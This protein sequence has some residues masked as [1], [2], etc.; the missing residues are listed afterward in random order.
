MFFVGI[1]SATDDIAESGSGSGS[2][3]VPYDTDTRHFKPGNA[4]SDKA[5]GLIITWRRSIHQIGMK[6]PT[7]LFAMFSDAGSKKLKHGSLARHNFHSLSSPIEHK[8]LVCVPDGLIDDDKVRYP[9]FLFE[10]L[11]P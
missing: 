11:F 5:A 2:G 9:R 7:V 6:K 10:F 1:L 4:I 8:F 3:F